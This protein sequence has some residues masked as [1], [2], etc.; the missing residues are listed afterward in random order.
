MKQDFFNIF[1][2][3]FKS[4]DSAFLH[5]IYSNLKR[6]EEKENSSDVSLAHR[7]C[8]FD[9]L[10]MDAVDIL[11]DRFTEIEKEL[12]SLKVEAAEKREFPIPIQLGTKEERSPLWQLSER[13]G[14]KLVAGVE[15]E[16]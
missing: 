8:F 10:I 6:A 11:V 5:S 16:N 14:Y 3:K 12:I 7:D 1:A 13:I 2:E 4:K 15:K 9:L